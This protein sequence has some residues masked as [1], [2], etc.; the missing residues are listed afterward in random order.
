MF[1][2]A[3]PQQK[4][5]DKFLADRISDDFSYPE[6]GGT[7]SDAPS[8]YVVDHNR[9]KLGSG[10]SD[11]E[12]AKTAIRQWKMFAFDWVKLSYDN[13]PI[14]VGQTVAIL[15]AHFGFYSL[16]AA[17]IVYTIDE[18]AEIERYGFAYGTLREH[19]EIGE[20]RFSVEFHHD[21]GGIWY[22]LYAFSKPGS[23]LARIGYPLS[24]YLQRSFVRDSKTAM[25]D[26]MSQDRSNL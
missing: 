21:S 22:D 12:R 18:S 13:T 25:L 9:V 1:S 16:S 2:I 14:E 6:I 26:F 11:Y 10:R 8:G 7:K 4:E 3:K 17:R 20:E 15:V 19:A 24:R 23:L 5:I